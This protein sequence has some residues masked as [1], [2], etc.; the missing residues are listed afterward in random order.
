MKNILLSTTLLF[1]LNISAQTKPVQTKVPASKGFE[2]TLE[3]RQ[4]K[5]GDTTNYIYYIKGDKVRIDNLRART[6]QSAGGF[7][8]DLKA[9][10]VTTLN[11]ERKVYSDAPKSNPAVINGKPEVTKTKNVKKI[12]GYNCIEYIVKNTEDNSQVSYWMAAGK[13]DFFDKL[14]KLW[15][16]KDKVSTYYTQLTGVAGMFPFFATQSSLD[17]KEE[18]RL[19]VTKVEKKVVDAEK[20]KVPAD[21]TRF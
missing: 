21:Y 16:R 9:G 7:L 18:L 1:A 17:G 10:T 5:E 11:V 6:N 19:E 3:F 8:F 15:N 20:M 14:I 12:L 2:G 13:F 4:I